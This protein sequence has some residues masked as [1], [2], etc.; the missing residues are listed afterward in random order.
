VR[1]GLAVAQEP[2]LLG[3]H[4]ALESSAPRVVRTAY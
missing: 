3:G 4:R 1:H 2:E